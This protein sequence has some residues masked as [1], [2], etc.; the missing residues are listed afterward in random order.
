M[1]ASI[2]DAP[3]LEFCV[4]DSPIRQQLARNPIRVVDGYA[5]VPEGPGLGV[6]VDESIVER[7]GV[8]A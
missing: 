4:E 8:R 6:D 3:L 1:L 5:A 7:Y 2:P